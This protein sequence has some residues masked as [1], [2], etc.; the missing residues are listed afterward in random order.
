MKFRLQGE[1]KMNRITI[2]FILIV[3]TYAITSCSAGD[4]AEHFDPKGKPPSEHTKAVL[5]QARTTELVDE[6]LGEFP[7]ATVFDVY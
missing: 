2:S 4:A 6:H 3:L 5:E 7:S 1:T